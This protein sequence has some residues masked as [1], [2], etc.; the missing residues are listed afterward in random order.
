M[1]LTT[2]L[3]DNG[4]GDWWSSSPTV[5]MQ[6]IVPN[7]KKIS[8]SPKKKKN[9][10]KNVKQSMTNL[11]TQNS[12]KKILDKSLSFSSTT[13]SSSS[14]TAKVVSLKPALSLTLNY[15]GVIRDWSGHVFSEVADSVSPAD[16]I[17]SSPFL[18]SG[19]SG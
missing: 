13:S 3:R 2:A 11:T 12:N 17:V 5:E 4:N 7:L 10:K 16:I 8:T 18:D 15:D 14:S 19:I 6:N 9:Q 1:N